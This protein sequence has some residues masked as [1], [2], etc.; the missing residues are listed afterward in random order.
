MLESISD[1]FV[2]LTV[3]EAYEAS[4]RSLTGETAECGESESEG[5]SVRVFDP[6]P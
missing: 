5:V 6:A 4:L 2:H 1:I 3:Y